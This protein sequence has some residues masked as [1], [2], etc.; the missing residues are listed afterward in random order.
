MLHILTSQVLYEITSKKMNYETSVACTWSFSRRIEDDPGMALHSRVH[1][2]VTAF[3]E[4]SCRPHAV[5]LQEV[6]R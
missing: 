3:V 5:T 6:G 2:Q 1:F 4:R